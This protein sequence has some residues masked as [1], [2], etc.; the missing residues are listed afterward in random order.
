MLFYTIY[1]ELP[2]YLR[3]KQV[4][5]YLRKRL[6]KQ[7]NSFF[8]DHGCRPSVSVVARSY[9]VMSSCRLAALG[10]TR[11]NS[12][13]IFFFSILEL[14]S[15]I[16][17]TAQSH[18]IISCH[19]T[20]DPA[21]CNTHALSHPLASNPAQCTLKRPHRHQHHTHPATSSSP[22]EPSLAQSP[23]TVPVQS[24]R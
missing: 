14:F 22:A 4:A 7:K 17:P 10:V 24:T 3:W 2:R 9:R 6:K 12:S 18:N 5:R 15:A 16:F 1:S 11:L 21:I 13:F 20:I 23:R 19:L 8:G